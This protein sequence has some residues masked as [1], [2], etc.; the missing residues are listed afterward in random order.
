[1]NELERSVC[2]KCTATKKEEVM[3]IL[4]QNNRL[5]SQKAA[6]ESSVY[7]LEMICRHG[8]EK[9]IIITNCKV[10]D[11]IENYSKSLKD[12]ES[13]LVTVDMEFDLDKYF[14]RKLL[15]FSNL[16][17]LVVTRKSAHVSHEY[18]PEHF[19]FPRQ[20]MDF[21]MSIPNIDHPS[22]HSAS[23]PMYTSV[24]HLQDGRL[25]L[26]DNSNFTCC[27]YDDLFHMLTYV[28]IGYEAHSVRTL[29][30]NNIA[31]SSDKRNC[32]ELCKVTDK[33]K[34]IRKIT[35]NT[36]YFGMDFISRNRFICATL[37]NPTSEWRLTT[38]DTYLNEKS[39]ITMDKCGRHFSGSV[40]VRYDKVSST[41]YQ[42]SWETNAVYAMSMDGTPKFTYTHTDLRFPRGVDLDKDGNIYI[43]AR[44]SHNIHQLSRTDGKLIRIISDVKMRSPVHIS[45]HPFRDEFVVTCDNKVA[46]VLLFRLI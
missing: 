45:F 35:T 29:C 5:Q 20:P 41:V 28:N 4:D 38:M 17:E 2:D 43:C 44:R 31:I 14:E 21:E 25:V 12:E 26:F 8:N 23:T 37:Y 27:L 3:S 7:L 40:Y 42:S 33:F 32:L 46:N 39:Y 11:Q 16:D 24:C 30:D 9:Q 34:F 10:N 19:R 13:K 15:M 36:Q 22:A 6:I 1:M 18:T